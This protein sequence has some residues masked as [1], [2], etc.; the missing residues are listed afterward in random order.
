LTVKGIIFMIIAAAG[1][2][3]N[4]FSRK[5]AEKK[6]GE[7]TLLKVKLIALGIVIIGISLLMIF[8]K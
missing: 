3:L 1:V 5:I 4:V 8:G 6:G 7:N 2:V